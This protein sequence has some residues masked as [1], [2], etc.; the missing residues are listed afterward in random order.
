MLQRPDNYKLRQYFPVLQ[1]S[2]E[3]QSHP[4]YLKAISREKNKILDLIAG[5]ESLLFKKFRTRSALVAKD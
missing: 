4:G 5:L 1:L 2:V 3:H